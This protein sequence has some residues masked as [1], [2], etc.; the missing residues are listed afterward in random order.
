MYGKRGEGVR[1][2]M[3]PYSFQAGYFALVII[4]AYVAM[5]IWNFLVG[6]K[7]VRK[8]IAPFQSISLLLFIGLWVFLCIVSAGINGK[9]IP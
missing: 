6:F 7:I 2:G 9:W 8:L 1:G 3:N 5:F 4:L